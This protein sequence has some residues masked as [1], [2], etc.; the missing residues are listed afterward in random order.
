M[1]QAKK[2][3]VGL[4]I[5]L[6][7]SIALPYLLILI[8]TY[9]YL[10]IK[11]QH[12]IIIGIIAFTG[13]IVWR[14]VKRKGKDQSKP[15]VALHTSEESLE[16]C[17]G[18]SLM[19]AQVKAGIKRDMDTLFPGKA[20]T[21]AGA[22][23]K[24][25]LEG[26]KVDLIV[27]DKKVQA[28]LKDGMYQRIIIK[29]PSKPRAPRMPKQTKAEQPLSEEEFTRPNYNFDLIAEV[30]LQDSFKMFE[31]KCQ[32]AFAQGKTEFVVTPDLLTEEP[33]A[34]A[35]IC[36]LLM[37]ERY[38]FPNAEVLPAGGIAVEIPI[39]KTEENQEE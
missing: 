26:G 16:Y 37:T 15:A 34:W 29:K 21:Y 13:I 20:W 18:T 32:N 30:F 22:F 36:R 4:G 23:V 10:Q 27:G 31:E 24:Q 35:S 1:E 39:H 19:L 9:F 33:E 5:T 3:V 6:L 28:I 38:G 11:Y 2:A 12:L 7:A 14:S 17:S 8:G 25:Y